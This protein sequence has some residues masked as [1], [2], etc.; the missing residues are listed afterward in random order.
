MRISALRRVMVFH[1][2]IVT[3]VHP[4]VSN[5]ADGDFETNPTRHPNDSKTNAKVSQSDCKKQ[6]L[7]GVRKS[8]FR[9]VFVFYNRIATPMQ[10]DR[11]NT[12]RRATSKRLHDDPEATSKRL[13]IA[14]MTQ[15]GCKTQRLGGMR[16][17][18]LCRILC[19]V[20]H[21]DC[22]ANAIRSQTHNAE[23]DLETAP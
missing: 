18:A 10:T 22:D 5:N 1:N 8:A 21:S 20:S 2:R 13:P 12:M 17:S 19:F 23:G 3:L 4:I 14:K 7:G 15:S 9:R 16:K 6:L 11:K